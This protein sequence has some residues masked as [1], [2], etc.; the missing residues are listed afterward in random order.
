[1]QDR[2]APGDGAA[3]REP[4]PLMPPEQW[5]R[6][7]QFSGD[8]SLTLREAMRLMDRLNEY[9][10]LERSFATC[11]I[12]TISP[13]ST[14]RRSAICSARRKASSWSSCGRSPGC[15]KKPATSGKTRRGYELTP[16]GVRKIGE[17]ALTDIFADLQKD[18]IGQHELRPRRRRRRPHRRH[19]AIRV[20]RSVPARYPEDD[21]ERGA[22]AS[23]VGSRRS[24]TRTGQAT[25]C[26]ATVLTPGSGCGSHRVTSRSTGPSTR[27]GRRPC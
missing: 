25:T 10:E 26:V 22:A 6:G 16:Q 15:W 24:R 8:E 2:A 23:G 5:R 1:M 13:S 20:R 4:R 11:A 12:G 14:M 19:Q 17:K 7:Y 21:H 9:D 3:R 27:R 18:H